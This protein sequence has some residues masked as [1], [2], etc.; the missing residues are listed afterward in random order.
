LAGPR[1]LIASLGAS[2]ALVA[3]AAL[4]LLALSVVFAFGGWSGPLGQST[5]K[6]PLVFA[7]SDRSHAAAPQRIASGPAPIVAP[8]P[9]PARRAVRPDGRSSGAAGSRARRA[10]A[11]STTS[12]STGHPAPMPNPTPRPVPPAPV[13][14]PKTGDPVRQIGNSLGSTVQETG[15]AL[16]DA[17]QPLAPPVGA[18]VEQVLNVVADVVRGA[19]DGLGNTLDRLLPKR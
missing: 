7:A 12:V 6:T 9:A 4:S 8:A 3:T 17:T 18:A 2:A 19:T 10:P 11:R 16:A 14:R 5:D 13:A 1:T 15:T